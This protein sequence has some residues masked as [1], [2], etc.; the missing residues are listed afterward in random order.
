MY[1]AA[2]R[3]YLVVSANAAIIPANNARLAK[4]INMDSEACR[5]YPTKGAVIVIPTYCHI[6]IS[7]KLIPA[8]FG[9]NVLAAKAITIPGTAPAAAALKSIAATNGIPKVKLTAK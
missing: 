2:S 5:I 8:C 4:V 9:G 6:V 7:P 3:I 1:F